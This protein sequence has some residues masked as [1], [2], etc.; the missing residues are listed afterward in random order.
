MALSSQAS[1]LLRRKY[2]DQI[3]A[4]ELYAMLLA[5]T[6]DTTGAITVTLP[7]LN[8][9]VNFTADAVGGLGIQAVDLDAAT[10]TEIVQ[11]TSAAT[12][13][14]AGAGTLKAVAQ[15]FEQ[16]SCLLGRIVSFQSGPGTYTVDLFPHG[17]DGTALRVIGVIPLTNPSAP[18]ATI[19]NNTYLD[20][21]R[22][23]Q[24]QAVTK[25]FF[26]PTGLITSKTTT[27]ELLVEKH[28]VIN[29]EVV[30]TG[31]LALP[32]H[33]TI[34]GGNRVFFRNTGMSIVAESDTML[35]IE[36][37]A[38]RLNCNDLGTFGVT[39][40]GSQPSASNPG[41]TVGELKT[42]IDTIQAKLSA[43]GLFN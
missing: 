2:Q 41:T 4:E 13:E 29:P 8:G 31:D 23:S 28:Y 7:R 35:R 9:A 43:L 24:A 34:A 40:V 12:T 38:I 1:R 26:D 10:S 30:I 5:D 20:V 25:E 14:I 3:L 22:I 42:T 18:G 37:P 33:L 39:P 11:E 36:A 21:F 16:R 32:G 17:T 6:E 27:V 15:P 19:P